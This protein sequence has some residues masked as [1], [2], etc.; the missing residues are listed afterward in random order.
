MQLCKVSLQTQLV[1][2]EMVVLLNLVTWI[3]A[4]QIIHVLW[5]FL[6]KISFYLLNYFFKLGE[7]IHTSVERR[8][9]LDFGRRHGKEIQVL[10]HFVWTYP[11]SRWWWWWTW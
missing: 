8:L 11:L 3:C 2:D 10:Y 6:N 4:C 9:V 7:M 1:T 5:M